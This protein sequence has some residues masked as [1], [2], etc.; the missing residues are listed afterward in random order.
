MLARQPA[1]AQDLIA[2]DAFSS[3]AVPMHLLTAEAMAMY[4]RALKPDGLLMVHISNRY[5]DLEPLIAAIARAQGWTARIRDYVP[6]PDEAAANS[7]H[8]VWIAMAHDP[9]VIDRL[10][11]LSA[12][13]SW[14]PFRPR[15]GFAPWTDD[16]A[17]ILP[18]LDVSD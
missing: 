14:Q 16:Y 9:A 6:T 4:A 3:D 2:L 11:A 15:P 17:T 12:P 13:Q 7:G 5:L 1:G 18:L 10:V 8:S